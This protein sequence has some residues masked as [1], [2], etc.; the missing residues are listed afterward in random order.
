MDYSDPE[1]KKWILGSLQTWKMGLFIQ[2]A[3]RALKAR[4]IERNKGN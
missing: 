3:V 2:D 4:F 1:Q